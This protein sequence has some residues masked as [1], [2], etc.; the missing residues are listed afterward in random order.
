[1][2]DRTGAVWI[3]IQ[4]G[5]KVLPRISRGCV[6]YVMHRVVG[7]TICGKAVGA[8][9]KEEGESSGETIEAVIIDCLYIGEMIGK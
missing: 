1:M 5:G 3:L 8:D 7:A 9:V 4:G 2:G 6:L